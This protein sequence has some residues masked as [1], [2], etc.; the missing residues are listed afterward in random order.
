VCSFLAL[1]FYSINLPVCHCTN[2]KQCLSVLLCS[3]ACGQGWWIP[4]EVLLLLRT[5]FTI[6]GFWLLQMNLQWVFLTIWIIER[7]LWWR[8]HWTCRL[9]SA[10][11]S[12]FYLVLSLINSNMWTDF[13]SPEKVWWD[14]F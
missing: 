8:L 14:I 3:T 1:Q 13:S 12:E 6:L 11:F 7:E 4:P 9:F 10:L 2:T 5:V